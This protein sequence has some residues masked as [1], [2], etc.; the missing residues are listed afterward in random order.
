MLR[1]THAQHRSEG[2]I[3]LGKC[4]HGR[5]EGRRSTTMKREYKN[6]FK[7]LKISFLLFAFIQ[8]NTTMGELKKY[9]IRYGILFNGTSKQKHSRCADS[10]KKSDIR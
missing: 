5:M 3:S 2:V 10:E 1:I 7:M 6:T 9:E 4:T 8:S